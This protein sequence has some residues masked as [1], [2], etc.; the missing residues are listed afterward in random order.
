MKLSLIDVNSIK[1]EALVVVIGL[2]V[3]DIDGS[4]LYIKRNVDSLCA[5]VTMYSRNFAKQN[6]N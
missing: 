1:F 3:V 4:S 2:F 5:N 6:E